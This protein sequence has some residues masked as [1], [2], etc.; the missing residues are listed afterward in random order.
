LVVFSDNGDGGDSCGNADGD[1]LVGSASASTMSPHQSESHVLSFIG[2]AVRD[3]SC[4]C[5]DTAF[6]RGCAM[7][8]V[9]AGLHEDC[10]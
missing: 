2:F 5:V 6:A 10:P 8:D 9:H 7:G 4:R 1:F 3:A